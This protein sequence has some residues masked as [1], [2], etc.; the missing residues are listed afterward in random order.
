MGYAEYG[1][2][3]GYPVFYFH[4]GL[5]C[6]IDATSSGPAAFEAGLRVIAVDRPGMGLSQRRAGMILLDWPHDVAELADHLNVDRFAVMGWSFG[7]AYAAA[8]AYALPAMVSDAILI[9]SGIPRNWPGMIEE[10]N[11]LD[12]TLLKLSGGF[13]WIERGMFLGM[14]VAARRTPELFLKQT[15]ADMAPQSREAISRDP[16]EFLLATIEAMANTGGVLDDYRIWNR[17]WGFEL[18][19]IETP[20]HIW[21]GS[22]DELCP[23]SWSQRLAD[24]IPQAE[25]TMVP[26]AGHFVARDNWPAIFEALR[27]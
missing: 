2:P 7:G 10:I 12:R 18:A 8:T 1:D 6:R 25:L 17:P 4:G 19:E 11:D 14:R 3:H 15:V 16:D 27:R 20:V 23:P 24:A 22:D 21:H 5:S 26:G 13:A 9:A